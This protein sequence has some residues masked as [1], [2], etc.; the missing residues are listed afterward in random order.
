MLAIGREALLMMFFGEPGVISDAF[1]SM[2]YAYP[3]VG[4]WSFFYYS[5]FMGILFVGVRF[6]DSSSSVPT[7]SRWAS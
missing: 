4:S 1:L 2:L 3:L 5:G 6:M 7:A